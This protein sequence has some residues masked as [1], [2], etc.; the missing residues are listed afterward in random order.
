M[1]Y[2]RRIEV[3]YNLI[4]GIT[5]VCELP[6]EDAGYRIWVLGKNSVSS[7]PL[8]QSVNPI[9]F[10]KVCVSVLWTHDSRCL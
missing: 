9:S 6:S 2:L 10:F 3:S 5:G 1:W 7:Q 4:D 8:R